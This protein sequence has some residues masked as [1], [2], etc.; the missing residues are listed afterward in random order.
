MN[1][2]RGITSA[3]ND[4]NNNNGRQCIR[5]TNNTSSSNSPSRRAALA[6][7]FRPTIAQILVSSRLT[8]VHSLF[9]C[10]LLPCFVLHSLIHSLSSHTYL[11]KRIPFSLIL[12]STLIPVSHSLTLFLTSL[13][14]SL[15]H[16]GLSHSHSL[17]HS[18]LTKRNKA[19]LKP[20]RTDSLKDIIC[21]T[22]HVS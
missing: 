17:T 22:P 6:L 18:L 21:L 10:R 1:G 15:T 2:C 5:I 4:N 20:P 12:T 14:H 7:L 9:R 13:T 16:S 8:L 11:Y 3:D 19:N